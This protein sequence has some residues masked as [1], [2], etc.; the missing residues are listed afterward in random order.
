ML[1][2]TH[3]ETFIG[4]VVDNN[5]PEQ[6]GRILVR[7]DTF[8]G[9]DGTMSNWIEPALP[10]VGGNG[11]FSS[12]GWCFIPDVGTAVEIE[13]NTSSVRDETFSMI[14][15]EA[16]N[17][18]WRSCILLP[19]REGGTPDEVPSEFRGDSYPFRRGVST[20]AGHALVFDDST[21]EVKLQ[22]TVDEASGGGVS[23]L[24]FLADGSAMVLTSKGMMI[25]MNQE[26]GEF[27]IIDT[28]SNALVMN[29]DGYYITSTDSDLIKAGGG[30][31][32]VMTGDMLIAASSLTVN[33]AGLQTPVLVEGTAGFSAMV[34]AALL[35]IKTG[36]AAIPFPTVPNLDALMAALNAGSFKS[37]RVSVE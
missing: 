5:D 3:S 11:A 37:V 15:F 8:M 7:C 2:G 1:S 25:F 9:P 22:A 26:A 21:G 29:A 18:R 36:L 17:F 27:S 14:S 10:F 6:R 24:D 20:V 34:A 30:K 4:F 13:I 33:V 28:N 19:G 31:V 32:S 12:A 35:E 16:P 23:V